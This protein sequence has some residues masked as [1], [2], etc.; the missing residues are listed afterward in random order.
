M[1]CGLT[2]SQLRQF[3]DDLLPENRVINT[4]PEW[5]ALMDEALGTVQRM[6][7]LMDRTVE[8]EAEDRWVRQVDRIVRDRYPQ[9]NLSVS[10]QQKRHFGEYE[11]HIH[12][13]G[14]P[15]WIVTGE[16]LREREDPL[17]FLEKFVFPQMGKDVLRYGRR[18]TNPSAS[19]PEP[20]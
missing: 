18:A 5:H 1:S 16:F 12:L 4:S 9:Y 15:F 19:A 10:K 14:N 8:H 20:A 2:G 6:V 11:V 13:D 7:D 3:R 17:P